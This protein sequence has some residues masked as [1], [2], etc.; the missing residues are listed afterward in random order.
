MLNSFYR[1]QK[2][3]VK[4][5][6]LEHYYSWW[7]WLTLT[8]LI[9]VLERQR[10]AWSTGRAL[11]QPGLSRNSASKNQT[12]QPNKQ[13]KPWLHLFGA[14]TVNTICYVKKII[15]GYLISIHWNIYKYGW[16]LPLLLDKV[17][18]NIGISHAHAD[19][20][21]H[22]STT[23]CMYHPHTTCIHILGKRN[24]LRNEWKQSEENINV[25]FF[26]YLS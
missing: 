11:G 25:V 5:S 1:Y 21:V 17:F 16:I 22:K 8:S 23:R 24:M 2:F 18:T 15:L 13:K 9:L 6:S 20:Y 4:L 3:F 19:I 7:W 12:N 14:K 10:P 26:P